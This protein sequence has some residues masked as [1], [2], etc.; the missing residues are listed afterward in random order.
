M[1]RLDA[2]TAF[3][4]VAE[5]RGFAPAARRLRLPPPKVTRLIAAL[6]AH[7]G[8]R[9]LHRTTRAVRLTDAGARYLE[10]TRRILGEVA[11]AEANARAERLAPAGRLVV[12]AP[13]VFGRL[14]VAPLLC[15]FLERHPAVVGEL[16]L[17]D[18]LANLIDDGVD[19]ALRIGH[20]DDSSL[21]AR[22]VGATR[23]V[24]VAAPRYLAA[25]RRLRGPADLAAHA[26]IQFTAL[27]PT[28]EWRFVARGRE[29]RVPIAPRLV[30]NSADA[31]IGHAERGGGV[32][33][34][35]A[36][37]AAEAIAAKRL[38]IV[39]PGFEPPPAPIQ[40]VY[41]SARLLSANVRAFVELA[42]TRRW[43][44]VEL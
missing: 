5:L 22:K 37:Q 19:V 17:S 6:E 18:H 24:L 13:R 16:H 35:L 31:A 30:T 39:L 23:R 10:R 33:M 28:R 8:I 12:A 26:T 32:A 4:A 36:Y 1:E 14:E 11:D 15:E 41:P 38:Q 21:T 29:L 25:R 34:V 2:M 42:A 44:F 40:L 7:L 20:L 43:Q 27:T 9:L 3:V